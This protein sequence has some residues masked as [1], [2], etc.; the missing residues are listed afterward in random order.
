MLALREEITSV[1][2]GCDR[3]LKDGLLKL[4]RALT[5][6][7]NASKIAADAKERLA[8]TSAELEAA[9]RHAE[10]IERDRALL[11]TVFETSRNDVKAVSGDLERQR[12]LRHSLQSAFDAERERNRELLDLLAA[13]QRQIAEGLRAIEHLKLAAR[14][15]LPGKLRRAAR[16]AT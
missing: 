10:A 6:A 9:G 16:I 7:A 2:E 11:Q 12:A 5:A 8:R 3:D 14:P 15:R 13:S 1:R 4:D